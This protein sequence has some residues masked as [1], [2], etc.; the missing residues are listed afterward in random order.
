MDESGS[1]LIDTGKFDKTKY[2]MTTTIDSL[3]EEDTPEEADGHSLA[4][5]MG[6]I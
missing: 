1:G 4:Y 3:I 6:E 2:I 5:L